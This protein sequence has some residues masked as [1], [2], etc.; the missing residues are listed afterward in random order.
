MFFRLASLRPD[1]TVLITRADGSVA[2]FAVDQVRS[3]PKSSFPT[4]LVYG[5]T[6]R[7]ALRLITCGGPIE[8]NSGHHRDNIVVLA[9]L[10]GADRG[11]HMA[12]AVVMGSWGEIR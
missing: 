5:D 11:A 10:V 1:D 6:D 8:S 7:A 9:S 12:N 2:V 4:Q 3:Y